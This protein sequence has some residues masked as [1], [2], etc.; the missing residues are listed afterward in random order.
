MFL[1]ERLMSDLRPTLFLAQ[2]S[3]LLAGNISLVHGDHRRVRAPS[4]A[5]SR[6]ASTRC[7]SPTPASPRGRPTSC[8]SAAPTTPSG[9]TCSWCAPWAAF[10]GH[11][12]FAPVFSRPA[13]GG[14]FI[15]GSG[16]GLRDARS[17]R[18]RVRARRRRLWPRWL[19]WRPQR[20]RR[21]PGDVRNCARAALA[22]GRGWTDAAV[23]SGATGVKGVTDE[24]R[25]RSRGPRAR[26]ASLC[27]GRPRRAY[28]GR[29]GAVQ[30]R[31]GHGAD[32]RRPGAAKRC[33]TSVGH[34]RG[35]GMVRLAKPL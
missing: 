8:W 6:A 19:A 30:R 3:N 14:G 35:E 13:Q 26:R 29:T 9:P 22:R 4:W 23:V 1:N 10:C 32:R 31:P 25:C 2:L 12:R 11:G 5:R 33:A 20:T 15:L 34:W 24:E 21:Q 16:G 18:A 27:D 7:A 28:D 17:A